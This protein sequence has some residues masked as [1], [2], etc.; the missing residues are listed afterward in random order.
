[1]SDYYTPEGRDGDWLIY[2]R[3]SYLS[4]AKDETLEDI[5]EQP[6]ALLRDIGIKVQEAE[7]SGALANCCG[8][9]LESLFP[10]KS[11][12]MAEKRVNQLLDCA[13]TIVTSCPICMAN[14]Q[15][16]T[17]ATHSVRDISEY[18]ARAYCPD[19]I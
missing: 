11:L 8:G 19:C 13:S 12:L 14:L 1:M 17:P 16:V 4:K 9:P 7:L 5:L 2:I 3:S 15:R 18:F 6:R 10:K